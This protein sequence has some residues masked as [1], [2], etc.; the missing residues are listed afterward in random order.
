[1]TYKFEFSK[2]FQ[3]D[4]EKLDK[5]TIKQIKFSVDKFIINPFLCDWIKLKGFKNYYRIRSGDY[6]IIFEKIETTNNII[7][8]F[9]KINH[10]REVYRDL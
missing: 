1:M 6:R 10:R 8:K 9:L 4:V 7:I 3:K 2:K 5:Q